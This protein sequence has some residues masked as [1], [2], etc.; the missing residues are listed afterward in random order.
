MSV[1]EQEAYSGT[2]VL[3]V[4]IEA[5]N[6]NRYLHS[7]IDSHIQPGMKIL[8]FGA[9]IGTF[10]VPLAERGVDVVCVEPDAKLGAGLRSA[11]LTVAATLDEIAIE[12]VDLVYTLNVLE[13]IA[14]DAAAV[15][16]LASKLKP[17]GTLLV[18]VPA[19]ELLYSSFDRKIGHLR[20]YEQKTL[21]GLVEAAGLRVTEV[22]Y[23]DSAGF[24]VALLY[25]VLKANDGTVGRGAVRFYDR[26]IFPLSVVLDTALSRW[27]GKNLIL[28]SRK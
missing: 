24:L 15:R 11:G 16:A 4:M 20:R 12:G 9:G 26:I 21:C 6:Y 10:A 8:D 5:K 18:Y 14:D 1:L 25:R 19:F 3:E 22:R 23:A 7:L 17:G 28:V 13:H 27:I 2:G